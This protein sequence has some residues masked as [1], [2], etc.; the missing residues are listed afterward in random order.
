MIP[1]RPEVVGF[2]EYGFAVFAEGSV[3]LSGEQRCHKYSPTDELFCDVKT[4]QAMW[5]KL[6]HNFDQNSAVSPQKLRN[7]VKNGI[8][9][10]LRGEFWQLIVG[11]KLLKNNAKFVYQ[12]KLS[13]VRTMLVDLGVTE[14]DGRNAARIIGRIAGSYEDE[15]TIMIERPK[16][17]LDEVT[18]THLNAFRQVLLDA[19]RT[20][21]THKM[22]MAGTI[23]GKEGR[24]ALFRILAVYVLYNPQVSYCQG[25]SYIAGMLLT[26]MCEEDAFWMLASLIERPKYLSGYFD[27]TL[28]KIQ[29]HSLVFERLLSQKIPRL[30]EHLKENGID[31]LLYITPWFMALYTSLPCWDSVLTIWDLLLLDGTSVIFQASLGI[32]QAISDDLL[33]RSGIAQILP[34]LLR[35]PPDRLRRSYFVPVMW[36]WT[37]YDWEVDAFQAIITDT[38]NVHCNQDVK[39]KLHN[40]E[41][42]RARKVPRLAK[43]IA[44]TNEQRDSLSFFERVTKFVGNFWPISFNPFDKTSVINARELESNIASSEGNL[45]KINVENDNTSTP[46]RRR[47]T[48]SKKPRD[49]SSLR[50]SPRIAKRRSPKKSTNTPARNEWLSGSPNAMHAFKMFN[51]PTPMRTTKSTKIPPKT[52]NNLDLSF[53][54]PFSLSPDVELQDI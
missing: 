29:R 38:S 26:Q 22:F 13:E 51:T 8:P 4:L 50:R 16:L 7:F 45:P 52:M 23:S 54:P 48:K 40:D 12:E 32:L 33:C 15:E 18:R 11:S 39:R 43:D 44:V 10:E 24:A 3:H 36:R 41:N 20:F 28:S 34:I 9:H 2:D 35:L 46:G 14:Y 27:S 21:P 42:C 37:I 47:T 25:M 1:G 30:H 5:K 31:P 53:P 49:N 6:D 17:E 19:D